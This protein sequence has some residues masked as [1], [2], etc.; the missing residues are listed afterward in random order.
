MN[1]DGK[2]SKRAGEPEDLPW[3]FAEFAAVNRDQALQQGPRNWVQ[4]F[5]HKPL[6]GFFVLENQ[7]IFGQWMLT[8]E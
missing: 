7:K 3:Y 2:V 5:K 6:E 4:P 8:K 1:R